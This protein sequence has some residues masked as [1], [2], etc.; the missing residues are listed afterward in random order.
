MPILGDDPGYGDLG[1]YGAT[2]VRSPN[3]DHL[4]TAGVLR[5]DA[6][7]CAPTWYGLLTGRCSWRTWLKYSAL[8]TGASLLIEKGRRTWRPCSRAVSATPQ[9]TI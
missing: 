8:S 3:I 2:P 9:R 4:A 5:T 7:T 6:S 1:S